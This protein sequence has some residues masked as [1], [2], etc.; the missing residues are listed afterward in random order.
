MSMVPALTAPRRARRLTV[1]ER[2]AS[3][4]LRLV[5]V[6]KPGVPLVEVRLRM[7]FLGSG[8]SHP[9]RAA[10]L[11]DTLLTGA[12]GYD[13]AALAAAVQ[14]LGA[15]LHAGVDAD[16]LLLSGNVL[17]TGLGGLLDLLAVVLTEARYAGDEVATERDRQIERLTIARSRAVVVAG[18]HLA[19]RMWGSHPYARDLPQPEAVGAV[20]PAQ[21][22]ALHRDRVRPGDAVLVLVGDV[23]PKRVL[24]E[25]EAAL[26]GWMG[27]AARPRVP[28]LPEPAGGPLLV[29][30][31]PGS[32][33]SSL[34]MG[35]MTVSR[36]DPGYP[37]MQLANL[38]FGGYFSSRWVENLRED[39]GYTY[40][41]NS[42]IDHQ[43]L[44]SV[45]TL[46]A[47]VATEVTAASL[48]ETRYELGRIATLPVT[49]DEVESVRQYAIGTLALSTATQAGLASTLSALSAFGLGLD[50]IIEHPARLQR[51]TV[52]D[53]SAA[54]AEYFAPARF[55]S[56]VVGDA[57][58]IAGPLAA[59]GGTET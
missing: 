43:V 23:S 19:E 32:V 28:R 57:A 5:A 15:D 41:P 14:S 35:R 18:E 1:A 36:T 24:D 31:R 20:T 30:D 21:L 4:G 52:D 53:V 7:P 13:R 10:V 29:V 51:V 12:G 9:A 54:A 40:G 46:D 49:A 47:E 17:G 3:N 11:A 27:F 42:R 39:K 38:V 37:A 55:A 22:R 33:Q 48:L 6:R 50:W 25:A 44:G 26:A 2:V 16:R 59:L 8:S 58:T 45:L 34:R 56:V